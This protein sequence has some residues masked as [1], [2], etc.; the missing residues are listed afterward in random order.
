[1]PSSTVRL[2]PVLVDL[3][4]CPTRWHSNT[5]T[6]MWR[7]GAATWRTQPSDFEIDGR[8]P[9][10]EVFEAAATAWEHII[11]DPAETTLVISHKSVLRALVCTALGLPAAAFRAFDIHNSGVVVFWV[12]KQGEGMLQHLNM[13]AHLS[14]EIRY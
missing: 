5:N 7:W 2:S 8:R 3:L 13:T 6:H 1:M 12:N 11:M 14:H 4:A 9:I 10:I